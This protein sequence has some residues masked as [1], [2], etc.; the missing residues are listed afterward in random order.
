[1]QCCYGWIAEETMA[2]CHLIVSD[3]PHRS[4][5]IK[6]AAPY[7]GCTAA[8]LRMKVNFPAPEIWFAEGE[9]ETAREIATALIH[10]G[11]DVAWIPGSVL[12]QVPH[13]QWTTAVATDGRS[14]I[15]TTVEGVLN[16][17]CGDRIVAVSGEP[18]EQPSRPS[19]TRHSLL[20]QRI[21]VHDHARNVHS[22]SGKESGS[23]LARSATVNK[24]GEAVDEEKDSAIMHVD[25]SRSAEPIAHFLDVY[26]YTRDGWR[27]A[28]I[29][30]TDVDFSELGAIKRP[31]ARANIRAI[32]AMLRQDL[33]AQVDERLQ[34]VAYRSS[35][36]GGVA[37]NRVLR[38][39]S[40]HLGDLPPMDLGSR[41]AFL[42]TK[43]RKH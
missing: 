26:A 19:S 12:A 31:T 35:V 3:P 1:M 15:L 14:L 36:V 16:I 17:G 9:K 38:S 10:A 5:D 41:L 39:I 7:F 34:H 40:P 4:P 24:P 25:D 20:T 18:P 29:T 2:E 43:G 28:R 30:Q 22:A 8:E 23:R 33:E 6:A 42:T 21:T 37:L 11:I 32:L 27:A 13:A